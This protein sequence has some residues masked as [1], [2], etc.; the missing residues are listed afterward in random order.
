MRLLQVTN[1]AKATS[2]PAY[3]QH[4]IMT[5]DCY[6]PLLGTTGGKKGDWLVF[7]LRK[8]LQYSWSQCSGSPTHF[9][10]SLTLRMQLLGSRSDV[11]LLS[12]GLCLSKCVVMH[13]SN[14]SAF[15]LHLL[16]FC[17][18]LLLSSNTTK[19]LQNTFVA[20][21]TDLQKCM[22]MFSHPSLPNYFL[23]TVHKT[24]S[25]RKIFSEKNAY[26]YLES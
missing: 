22:H 7:L 12:F 8:K 13:P 1:H 10:P 3:V 14:S 26:F 17:H 25:A 6:C 5:A 9:L 2:Q 4:F 20:I 11:P 19:I 16:S 24:D 23:F 21:L 18:E 15:F